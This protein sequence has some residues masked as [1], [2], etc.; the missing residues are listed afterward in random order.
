M[1]AFKLEEKLQ[2]LIQKVINLKSHRQKINTINPFLD[3]L[4]RLENAHN[5]KAFVLEL[6]PHYLDAIDS[7]DYSGTDPEYVEGILD[8]I[9]K[10]IRIEGI[11]ESLEEIVD[12]RRFISEKLDEI[13]SIVDGN[14]GGGIEKGESEFLFPVLDKELRHNNSGHIDGIEIVIVKNDS[15]TKDNFFII[16]TQYK[17]DSLLKQQMETSWKLTVEHL[18]EQGIKVKS[19]HDIVIKFSNHEAEYIGDS[20]GV[21]ITIGFLEKAFRLYNSRNTLSLFP[22]TVSTGRIDSSG[23]ILAVSD[24][25]IELKTKSVFFSRNNNFIVPKED[26]GAAKETN[27]ALSEKYP[28]RKLTVTGVESIYDLLNRR[29]LINF[30]R[31]NII[32]WASKNIAKNKLAIASLIPLFFLVTYFMLSKID[33]N[34]SEIIRQADIINIHNQYGE[35]LWSKKSSFSSMK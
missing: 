28:K 12:T 34:P 6:L 27:R 15:S 32:V 25:L 22:K 20:L 8:K 21:A 16:P 10:T 26:E 14:E 19:K 5:Y 11:L 35:F 30:H 29:N 18:I 23:K 1:D 31:Q 17:N 24:K 33:N 2:S 4:L 3:D 9:D 13:K 7:A